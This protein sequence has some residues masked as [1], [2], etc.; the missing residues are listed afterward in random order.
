MLQ[1]ELFTNPI[2]KRSDSAR[3]Q[4]P[5]SGLPG[6][7]LQRLE[8][9]NW[10]TF[11]RS[12]WTFPVDGAN[13]LLTGDIGSGKSTLVDAV[14][15]LL[16]PANRISYN[17]AAG[18]ETRERDLRSYVLGYYKSERNEE[19]G[20]TRPVGLRGPEHYSVVLAVF[21][22][23]D[24]ELGGSEST[25]TLAQ[26]FRAREAGGQ[27]ER[28]YV[29]ADADMSIT[30]HFS[31]EHGDGF[32]ELRS[33]LRASGAEIFEHFPEYGGASR[34]RLGIESEQVLE[35]FHQTVSMKA[36]GNLNDFVR[37][38]MLEPLDMSDRI[39]SLIS[40]FDDLTKA[41]EAVLR[42]RH[43]LEL[44]DPLIGVL[45]DHDKYSAVIAGL[46]HQHQ[47]LPIY[48]AERNQALLNAEIGRLASEQHRIDVDVAAAEVDL[49][50][51]RQRETN[52]NVAIAQNGGDRLGAID[53][54]LE[55][56]RSDVVARRSALD[57]FNDRL[58]GLG[59]DGHEK[60]SAR[61]E[62]EAVHSL[63]DG[64]TVELDQELAEL[65]NRVV[66][67]RTDLRRLQSDAESVNVELRS[68]ESRKSNLPA[69]SLSLRDQLCD[70]LSLDVDDL[71]FA[72]ELLQVHPDAG[73][74]EGAAER[75]LQSFALSLLVPNEHYQAV[76]QW[77]NGRH[78]G[79]R[80]VY[81]RVP[82][83]IPVR[84]DPQRHSATRLLL[85]MVE[86]KPDTAFGPW[87]HNELAHRADH[88]CVGSVDQFSDCAKA[89]TREGQVK[90]RHRHEK[91]DRSR[92][93]DR[94]RYV[95]G[96]TNEA[97]VDVL[98]ADA[99]RI[100][101]ELSVIRKEMASP[102]ARKGVVRGLLS[103]LKVL[104]ESDRWDALDWFAAE[105]RI[106]SLEDEAA[107]IR[108][109]SD[110]LVTL[111]G[112][113]ETAGRDRRETE[114]HRNKLVDRRG[115][116][117]NQYEQASAQLST[118]DALLTDV[119]AVGIARAIYPEVEQSI[120]ADQRDHLAEL[121]SLRALQDSTRDVIA[122]RRN[123]AADRLHTTTNQ[124]LRL[125]RDFRNAYAQDAAE[126]DDS[127]GSAVEYRSLR[128]RV[129]TDD[130]PRFEEEFR[131]SL[132]E[133][134]INEIAG[135]S[136]RLDRQANTIQER[137]G[138]IN[139]S[140]EAIDYNPGRYIRLKPDPTPNVEIRQF[141]QDLRACT[142][143]MTAGVN[144]DQYSENRFLQ[145][146]ELISRFRGR[147][148][149]SDADRAWTRRVTD[150]RQW[151]VFSASER[152]RET[153]QEYESYS[154]SSGKSGGQKEKLAY[155]IL[156]ASLAYQFKLDR[157]DQSERSFRFVVI[158]EA[159]GRG[160][161][162]STRYALGLFA[163]LGLQLLIVTPLTKIHVIEHYVAS[164][165]FVQ[166]L[167]GEGSSLQHITIDE[168]RHRRA[169]ASK[170][171]ESV[172][173]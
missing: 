32:R 171:P 102:D 45:D 6:C 75:V 132:R 122:A 164:V 136:A 22:A 36:V 8:V 143:N 111:T 65:D 16:L 92:I 152:W 43:Q 138:R 77:I 146:K 70:D 140:L 129:A 12:V 158:D 14:T 103:D 40:H 128:D 95:L 41:H 139:G 38:H 19:T 46:D 69:R 144:D 24:L 87:L 125:M 9:Y 124:A 84:R 134:T 163:E 90:N 55:R 78:L 109:S 114:T 47:A 106:S 1:P 28:F 80:L 94:R 147:E 135:L 85:D 68:L 25:V 51:L 62:F 57:R 119:D 155:T 170:S 156:A 161:E 11:D 101:I 72:G 63:I 2:Q 49:D 137:V 59:I 151:F 105:G 37:S 126:L 104:A 7:R 168:Y 79:T 162:D 169:G 17:K 60:I 142:S 4:R 20:G 154:D 165:G 30:Q 13:A 52:L 131:R 39:Q 166:N 83:N 73:D 29:V 93:D 44:L 123:Q 61:Q 26:V 112:E 66:E 130:L 150:V 113:L 64:H 115:R 157:Q 31:L 42:A 97:K 21:A 67:L 153:D 121:G 86:V 35:L 117:A 172:T 48:F 167:N 3:A 127:I 159:F 81:F 23:A 149:S 27:P 98:I 110:E 50:D 120:P 88:A 54:E 116:V 96:W 118:T 91:D 58:S 141:Q 18:A 10:G 82:P 148:G 5:V 15:T 145:V 34:R 33:R 160:S 133:N 76:A 173:T 71:P 74:W 108:A 53:T 56:L 99:N 107:R 100:Q 89:I